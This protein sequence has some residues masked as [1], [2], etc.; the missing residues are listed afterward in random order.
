MAHSATTINE[1]G[2]SGGKFFFFCSHVFAQELC[3]SESQA[4]GSTGMITI[5][6]MIND[7]DL[8]RCGLGG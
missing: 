5:M 8:R 2:S 6:I 3:G 7:K 1:T 4:S